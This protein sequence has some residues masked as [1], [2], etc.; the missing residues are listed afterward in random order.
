MHFVF[1]SG[2]LALQP[3]NKR[4][5][6]AQKST[7]WNGSS[8]LL[9]YQTPWATINRVF[10]NHWDWR[11]MPRR[12]MLRDCNFSLTC[13][14]YPMSG[15]KFIVECKRSS[16]PVRNFLQSHHLL[17]NFRGKCFP[18]NQLKNFTRKRRVVRNLFC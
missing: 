9:L 7:S 4:T 11:V 1:F 2:L 8:F 13:Q 16:R 6:F 14:N 15:V 3:A 18:I 12:A 10:T 5:A 17:A